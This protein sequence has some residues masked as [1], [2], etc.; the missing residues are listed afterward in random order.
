MFFGEFRY[1]AFG[2][3]RYCAFGDVDK[4]YFAVPSSAC[5]AAISSLAISSLYFF[6]RNILSKIIYYG[7]LPE[8]DRT[9]S[10]SY[11]RSTEFR[12]LCRKSPAISFRGSRRRRSRIRSGGPV[13]QRAVGSDERY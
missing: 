4:F 6:S 10:V 9:L 11:T 7:D 12:G 13:K 3:F 2:E 8:G 1:S 5:S